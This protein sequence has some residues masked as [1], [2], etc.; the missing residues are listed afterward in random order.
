MGD[1]AV[2]HHETRGTANRWVTRLR[3]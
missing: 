2:T 1:G 3:R